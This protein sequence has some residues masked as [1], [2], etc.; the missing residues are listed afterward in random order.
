MLSSSIK[1]G[2]DSISITYRIEESRGEM[3]EKR[4]AYPRLE[5]H[6]DEENNEKY[7]KEV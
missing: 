1:T 7:Y 5:R 4:I 6:K 2:I 3:A